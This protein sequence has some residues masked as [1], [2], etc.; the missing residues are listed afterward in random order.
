MALSTKEDGSLSGVDADWLYANNSGVHGLALG[1]RNGTDLLLSADITGD[2]VW[3]HSIDDAGK[4]ELL[5]RLPSPNDGGDPRHLLFHP[6]M[7]WA[8]VVM[9]SGNALVAIK[10]Q[11]DEFTTEGMFTHT[12]IP[13]GKLP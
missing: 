1:V 8:Y 2:A 10:L 6:N 5:S 13:D 9:E 12:L 4:A 11:G 3:L 7:E